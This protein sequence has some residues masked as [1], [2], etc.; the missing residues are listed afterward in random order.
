MPTVAD[1][2]ETYAARRALGALVVR[3]ATRWNPAGRQA[4][5]YALT[6]IDDAAQREDV[7]A[8]NELNMTFQNTLAEAS[9]LARIA[10]MLQL[11]SEQVLMFIA[12]VG[13]RYAFPID[14]IVTRDH[15]LF[16]AI[17]EEDRQLAV[18]CWREKMDESVA[19]M[20]EQV[21]YA[22]RR[23]KPRST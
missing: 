17:D 19:Y 12:V 22:Y 6:E 4:V 9:G 13:I 8:A 5:L 18:E 1:V 20:I 3:A 16:A 21:E 15:Q 14:P 23:R 7:D 11:L 10:P 2:I